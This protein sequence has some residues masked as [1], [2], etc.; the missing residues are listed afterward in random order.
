MTLRP[1]QTKEWET[2]AKQNKPAVE[3]DSVELLG[4]GGKVGVDAQSDNSLRECGDGGEETTEPVEDVAA[5]D[6]GSF[7]T[8]DWSPNLTVGREETG[9]QRRV[10]RVLRHL[11]AVS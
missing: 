11:I 2:S 5:A 6:D 9:C 3:S 7:G 4:I 10:H 1:I 8:A